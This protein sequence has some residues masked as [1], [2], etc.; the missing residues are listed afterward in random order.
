MALSFFTKRA[1]VPSTV[2]L[3]DI[4]SASVGVALAEMREGKPPHLSALSRK[5]I[6]FQEAL[7]SAQF[8]SAMVRALDHAIKE[9]M[10]GK[11]G[12]RVPEHIFCT[13]SAP[14]FILKN[15]RF[16]ISK[17]KEFE[18]DAALIEGSFNAEIEKL[19]EEVKDILPLKDVA[20]IEKNIIQAKLNGYE[21]KDRPYGRRAKEVELTATVSLSSLRAIEGIRRAIDR[22]FN[23]SSIHFGVFPVAAFSTIR[24]LF[25][26]ERDFLFL[27]IAGEATSVS[28]VA[29]DILTDTVSFPYGKNFFIREIAIKLRTSHVE[30]MTLFNV[31]LRGELDRPRHEEIARVVEYCRGEWVA[32]L[33]KVLAPRAPFRKMF[34]MA[35]E[36]TRHL[37]EQTM[38]AIPAK[39]RD[40]EKF[41]VWY[42]DHTATTDLV[43]FE[44]GVIRD[45]FLAIEALFAQKILIKK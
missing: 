32:R 28:F 16:V 30:A 3:V 33:E 34:F 29:Q 1:R 20:V 9:V 11:K 39:E 42:L 18:I 8:I 15:R 2:L 26:H 4:G 12:V 14:W 22:S 45:P 21:I 35:D 31:F 40:A 44:S 24:D 27:D 10:K 19:K 43:I 36:E 38:R 41:E 13:L 5:D 37:F 25:P 23:V 7:T 6:P 17:D